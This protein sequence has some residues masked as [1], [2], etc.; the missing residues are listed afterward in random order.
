[1]GSEHA[2]FTGGEAAFRLRDRHHP[3]KRSVLAGAGL[4]AIILPVWDF[5]P[6]LHAP[7]G[8]SLFFLAILLG[9][10]AVG[11]LL[12]AGALF[13]DSTELRLEDGLLTL[14]RQ[15]PFRS[16]MQ[17]LTPRDIAAVAVK[18]HDWE[19]RAAT[20]SVEVV[21]RSGKK[22]GSN[23]YDTRITAEGIVAEIE[24]ALAASPG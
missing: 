3:L 8:P 6:A 16:K 5:W 12:L 7:V 24:A 9:A 13:D 19:S 23:D 4:F 17:A 22:I 2:T 1:M 20:Y 11:G 21:L 18:V 15:N 14:T 10:W